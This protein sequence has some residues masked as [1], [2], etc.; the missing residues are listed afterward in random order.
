MIVLSE[1]QPLGAHTRDRSVQAPP[2]K[3]SKQNTATLTMRAREIMKQ[4]LILGEPTDLHGNYVA[5]ALGQAGHHV[6]FINSLHEECPSRTTL[7]LD[8]LTDE[9]TSSDWDGADA[10]WT[11]RLPLPFVANQN[12]AENEGF[13]LREEQRFSRWLI[14]LQHERSPIRWVNRPACAILAENKFIQLRNARLQGLRVPRTLV[15]AQPDRFRAFIQSEKRVVAKPLSGYSWEY[16]SGTALTAFATILDAERASQL[17]DEDIAQCVT[18]YQEV[19]EKS[20]DVRMVVMGE[21]LFAY[22]IVQQGEQ[23]FDFRVGFLHQNHLKYEAISV[24][25]VLSKKITGLMISMGVNFASADFAVTPQ[26]EFVFLDLNASGQWLFIEKASPEAR[27]GQKFCSYFVSGTVD[28][29]AEKLFPS[30]S[31][32]IASDAARAFETMYRKRLKADDIRSDTWK[33]A[34]G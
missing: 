1:S 24:P 4:F 25:A 26:G 12:Y 9:F 30:F 33:E 22:K 23:H 16:S 5:W 3:T 18:M 17:A 8:D 11:R 15:T 2:E 14:E 7:Y 20:C 31:E 28:R 6:T 32:Y 13:A 27:V 10:A 21:S 29:N 34:T 19:I